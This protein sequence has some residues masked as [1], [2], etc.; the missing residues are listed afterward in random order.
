MA[1]LM[2]ALGL[3]GCQSM[4]Q[5]GPSGATMAK[6]VPRYG[7]SDQ[8]ANNYVF[9]DISKTVAMTAG[10]DR[11]QA[12]GSGFGGGATAAPPSTLGI[13]DVV[14]VTMFEAESG[15]LFVPSD[16]GGRTGNFL[17]LPQQQ[18]SPRGTLSI[19]Y[20]GEIRAA[21]LSIQAV[22]DAIRNKLE[23]RAI[24]PQVVITLVSA[25]SAQVS[26]LGDV[27]QPSQ[28]AIDPAGN[29]LLDVIARAGG[30][31][32]G[33]DDANVSVIRG[34]QTRTVK[35]SSLITSPSQN[36]YVRPGD[37]V[38]VRAE[39]RTYV[40]LGAMNQNGIFR[41]DSDRVSLAQAIGKAGGLADARADP[42]YVYLYREVSRETLL[43]LGVNLA[44][45]PGP[46]VPV[47][48]NAN[49]REPAAMFAASQFQIHD[50]DV[51]YVSNAAGYDVGKFVNLLNTISS[52]ASNAVYA[53][54][55]IGTN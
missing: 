52:T 50:H 22:Q 9:I 38:Y 54:N 42:G 55:G 47:V 34:G 26:V 7:A 35:F 44:A 36:G 43:K 39:S 3:A 13:G 45:F 27:A 21:G 30:I 2:L 4:P 40:V 18:V 32:D 16:A 17:A 37:T 53:G 8:R 33:G 46:K 48:F 25:H 5:S 41:F 1:G 12:S 6:N 31:R 15:G 14:Q 24:E 23:D 20:A 11:P 28:M 19:P 49:L 29:R 10:L 51:L